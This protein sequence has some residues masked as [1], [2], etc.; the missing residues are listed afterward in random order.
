M[1]QR[2]LY[3]TI[4]CLLCLFFCACQAPQ[5]D[6]GVTSTPVPTE[7]VIQE[8]TP[9][10]A[11]TEAVEFT[12]VPTKEPTLTPTATPTPTPTVEEI[13]AAVPDLE[14]GRAYTLGLVPVEM[15]CN[16]DSIATEKELVELIGK[17]VEKMDSLKSTIEGEIDEICSSYRNERRW[18]KHFCI[19]D[20]NKIRFTCFP[21][22]NI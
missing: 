4:A 22:F 1:N 8:N 15:M 12:P 17:A 19:P 11:P 9:T 14:I 5:A 6:T 10:I 2:K 16:Y 3:G 20:N 21:A 7:S 13:L 18:K